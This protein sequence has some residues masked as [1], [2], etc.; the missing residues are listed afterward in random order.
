[1][2]DIIEKL[3]FVVSTP[4]NLIN[5]LYIKIPNIVKKLLYKTTEIIDVNDTPFCVINRNKFEETL[6]KKTFSQS[7]FNLIKN[8]DF[9]S[10]GIVNAISLRLLNKNIFIYKK[11]L[12]PRELS[13]F[14]DL[15]KIFYTNSRKSFNFVNLYKHIYPGFDN[16]ELSVFKYHHGLA[17]FDKEFLEEYIKEGDCI[18]GGAFHLDSAVV[19]SKNYKFKNIYSYELDLNNYLK[20]KNCLKDNY[21]LIKNIKEINKGLTKL[22]SQTELYLEGNVFSNI[23]NNYNYQKNKTKKIKVDLTTIDNEVAYSSLKIKFIK[24]DIEGE[25]YSAILGAKETI[26]KQLPIMSI[27]I[28]HN[29]KD[30]FEIKPLIEEIAPNQYDFYIRKLAPF[31]TPLETYLICVPKASNLKL[32]DF[33]EEEIYG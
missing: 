13:D 27:S 23:N 1:M 30:F 21:P 14:F 2:Q 24:L 26:K 11:D 32:I 33:V 8:L 28:Y 3:K 17:L 7:Y 31:Y 29:F 18:D 16:Y 5:H 22:S 20:G 9:K 4:Q 15:N 12:T 6:F 19:F 10:I 25:E